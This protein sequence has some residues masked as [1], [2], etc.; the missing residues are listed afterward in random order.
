MKNVMAFV[1]KTKNL[2]GQTV[3]SDRNVIM[4]S[5]YRMEVVVVGNRQLK[6]SSLFI[7]KSQLISELV[8]EYS[9]IVC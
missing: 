1:G 4:T 6:R 2:I 9:S 7:D 3:L 8:W 5:V